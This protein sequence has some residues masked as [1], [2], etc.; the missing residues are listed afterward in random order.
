MGREH[1][2]CSA[3]SFIDPQA[4]N[5][6]HTSDYSSSLPSS[7]NVGHR[8]LRAEAAAVAGLSTPGSLHRAAKRRT[9]LFAV[10]DMMTPPSSCSLFPAH[11]PWSLDSSVGPIFIVFPILP[12]VDPSIR[13]L[14]DANNHSR[15]VGAVTLRSAV[16]TVGERQQGVGEPSPSNRW[17]V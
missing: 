11:L 9:S 7:P 3:D 13:S 10:L 5:G 4:S 17:V 16:W 6:G 1:L 2:N 8:E 14:T 12:S 15:I